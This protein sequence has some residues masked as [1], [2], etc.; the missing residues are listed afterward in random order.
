[1]A[2][3]DDRLREL[4]RLVAELREQLRREQLERERSEA[5]L[6]QMSLLFGSAPVPVILL[7]IEGLITDV[8]HEA[9]RVLG[10]RRDELVGRPLHA[11]APSERRDLV[12]DALARC[13]EGRIVRRVDHDLWGDDSAWVAN[14]SLFPL[15][16]P[17]GDVVGMAFA[18]DIQELK[19]EGELLQDVNREL[20]ELASLD[21]LTGLANRRAY[22][23]TLVN[24]LGRAA[25]TGRP[26][27]MAMIDVDD[28]KAFNDALGHPAGDR[29][30]KLVAS[31]L[32]ESLNRP[33]DQVARYGGEE[34][35]ALLPSTGIGGARV[36]AER[37][38]HAVENQR[39][40]HPKSPVSPHVT[41]SIGVATVRP[42]PG[43][44]SRALQE[45]ADR[46]LYAAKRRGRNRIEFEELA[47]PRVRPHDPR[48]FRHG[49]D[50]G[51]PAAGEADEA[52]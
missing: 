51:P 43:F 44:D 39:I 6:W 45:A 52:I 23:H 48:E 30:L 29:C 46:A 12:Q 9:E 49:N 42:V 28:F 5:A 31:A 26:M 24:E 32:A 38:R 47:L 7:D 8:N 17:R 2:T 16:D 14:G 35:V 13:R 3:D 1:M 41:V 25:R 36:L 50:S 22:E 4:E 34:F 40:V 33:G 10:R 18:E 27:S 21:P 37:M 11:L 15:R 19:H 20:R